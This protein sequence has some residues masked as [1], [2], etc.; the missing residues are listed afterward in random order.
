MA[1]WLGLL[2]A[3]PAQAQS[4]DSVPGPGA[5]PHGELSD[6]MPGVTM[7]GMSMPGMDRSGKDWGDGMAGALG[8]YPM[9][10]EASGTA[11]QP[12]ASATDGFLLVFSDWSVMFHGLLNGVYDKQ[13]GPRGGEKSFASGMLMAMAQ[14]P[15]GDAG[16]L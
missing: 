3:A 4:V 5:P 1:G 6:D 9:S 8:A 2:F 11:W 10:R 16:T 14:R 12:D 7:P 15:V 13:D